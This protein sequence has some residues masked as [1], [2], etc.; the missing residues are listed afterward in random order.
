MS[1][2][3]EAS[4]AVNVLIKANT[5]SLFP[6]LHTANMDKE[7]TFNLTMGQLVFSYFRFEDYTYWLSEFLQSWQDN[8]VIPW[9]QIPNLIR[10][11]VGH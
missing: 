7:K 1:I 8:G 6:T 3:L 9:G 5:F 4:V 2:P 11:N 10:L